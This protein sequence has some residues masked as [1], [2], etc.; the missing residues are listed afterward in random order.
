M[1]LQWLRTKHARVPAP[2]ACREQPI[3]AQY[4]PTSQHSI[5]VFCNRV[6]TQ[7]NPR[8]RS[9]QSSAALSRLHA[10]AI[11]TEPGAPISPSNLGTDRIGASLTR[12]LYFLHSARCAQRQVAHFFVSGEVAQFCDGVCTASCR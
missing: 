2:G 7:C 4:N 3:T 6:A 5:I 1:V 9:P 10:A 12:T 8:E 11:R